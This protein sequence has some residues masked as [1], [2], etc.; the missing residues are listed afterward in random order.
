MHEQ[1]ENINEE[2]ETNSGV[3]EYSNWTEKFTRE[4]QQTW[5]NGRKNQ[6]TLR[7]IIWN[8]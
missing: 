6:Q 1:N 8:Y 2:K 5:P 4:D 3:D 7:Q